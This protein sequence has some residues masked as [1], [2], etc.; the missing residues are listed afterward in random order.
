[1]QEMQEILKSRDIKKQRHHFADKGLCS[2]SYGFSSRHVWMWE[3]VHKEGWAPK[4]WWLWTIALEKALERPLDSKEM[5]SVHPKGNQPWM[6]TGRTDTEAEAPILWPP[7]AKS[8][9]T[10]KDPD[11]GKDWGQEEK[12]TTEDKMV[13]WHHW[14]N[15]NEFQQTPGDSE[16]QGSLVSCSSCGHKVGLNLATKQ[17]QRGFWHTIKNNTEVIYR[18]VTEIH[19]KVGLCI[20]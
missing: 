12:G 2:Q 19:L 5:K 16:G 6:L 20:M 11:A 7:D 4:N 9:L 8:W 10:G 15:R 3:L 17:Q 18:T 14:L 13:G 1:M